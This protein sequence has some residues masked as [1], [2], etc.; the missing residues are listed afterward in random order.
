[1]IQEQNI[2]VVVIGGG[3][4]GAIAAKYAALQGVDTLLLE[5]KKTIG[6]PIRCGEFFPTAKELEK[7]FVH[8]PLVPE[9]YD[10]KKELIAQKI[11]T[12]R[13]FSPKSTSF[14]MPLEGHSVYREKFEEY[15]LEE[16]AK[17]GAT[18]QLNTQ[19]EKIQAGVVY[20]HNAQYSAKA[21]IL[22]CG[23]NRKL[24]NPLG[25]HIQNDLAVCVQ[26]VMENLTIE[27][28]IVE[29]HYGN[30]SPGGYAWVIPKGKDRA[31][32]GLGIRKNF[33][34]QNILT[35]LDQFLQAPIMKDKTAQG[36]KVSTIAGLVPVN[37]PLPHTVM[38]NIILVGDA[39]GH[40]MAT[41]GGGIPI[42]M[43]CGRIAGEAGADYIRHGTSLHMYE[44]QWKK[45][46]GRELSNALRTRKRAD[47]IVYRCGW[48]AE[49]LMRVL[50]TK[51]ISRALKCA[52]V[53][54]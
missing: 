22:A 51:V 31:N 33:Y 30:V 47:F 17:A 6:I 27:P 37:G 52:S 21:I 48:L 10:I 7:I 16:A 26:Y 45:E 54:F 41:N 2:D 43:I 24:L 19:V 23:P 42:V 39:A 40:V 28:N 38:D 32:V 4:A 36:Q 11:D 3:P 50:G 13:V 20:T 34:K 18:I 1:M 49:I 15:L 46:C 29:M 35:L 14:D 8:S 25:I 53:G 44:K 12:V 5:Q 9:L